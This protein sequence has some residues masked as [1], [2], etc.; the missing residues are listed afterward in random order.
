[1][2]IPGSAPGSLPRAKNKYLTKILVGPMNTLQILSFPPLE[3][4]VF[5]RTSIFW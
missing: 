1:M 3:I 2:K 5:I 4:V